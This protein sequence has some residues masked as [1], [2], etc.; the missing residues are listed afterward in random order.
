[1][2]HAVLAVLVAAVYI[3][4][5]DFWLWHRAEPVVFGVL[6]IGLAYHVLYSIVAAALM[7]LLVRYEFPEDGR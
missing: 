7:W 4:H 3:L 5:Q 1:M 6:P 2:R